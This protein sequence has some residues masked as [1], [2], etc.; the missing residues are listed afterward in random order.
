MSYV[1]TP[2]EFLACLPRI[3]WHLDDPMADAAAVPLWFAAREAPSRSRWSCPA[4]GADELFGQ[5]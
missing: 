4:K 3:V 2:E 5:D 1:I